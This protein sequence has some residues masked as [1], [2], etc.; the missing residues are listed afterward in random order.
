MITITATISKEYFGEV[1][2][3]RELAKDLSSAALGLHRDELKFEHVTSDNES[4]EA[5][6]VLVIDTLG[7][8]EV[9]DRL[10][11]AFVSAMQNAR[12][13]FAVRFTG[14][15]ANS[16]PFDTEEALDT[17][18]KVSQGDVRGMIGAHVRNLHES[19]LTG[20]AEA[21]VELYDR[22]RWEADRQD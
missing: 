19:I 16:M 2:Y 22:V 4:P 5:S 17:A 1:V 10:E 8:N 7:N 3:F 12:L 20:P 11:Q 15:I 6:I 14:T 9:A 13:T 18:V 21:I